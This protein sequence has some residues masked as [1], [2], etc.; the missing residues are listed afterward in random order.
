VARRVTVPI[1]LASLSLSASVG[2][3]GSTTI[4]G[5]WTNPKRSVILSID[6]CG[7]ELCGTVT[8]ASP[9]AIATARKGGTLNLVGTRLVSGLRADGRGG[10]QGRAL[11]P[12][13]GLTGK[14]T[15]RLVSKGAL[16]VRGCALSGLVCRE[17]LW[18]RVS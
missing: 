3:A 7:T 8:W 15:I 14:A 13:R 18:A 9:K 6:K 11:E 4:E 2:A 17:Q 16:E 1:F 12:K 10:F 5:R